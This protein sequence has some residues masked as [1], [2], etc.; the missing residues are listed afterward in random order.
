MH[1]S[2][3]SSTFRKMEKIDVAL[4]LQQQDVVKFC[5]RLSEDYKEAL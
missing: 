1:S 5:E 2:A 3:G 4:N